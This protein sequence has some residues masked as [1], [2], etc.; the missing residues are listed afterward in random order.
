MKKTKILLV[1]LLLTALVGALALVSKNQNTQKGA[2]FA[3]TTLSILP[4]EKITKAVGE[5]L[6]TTVWFYTENSSTKV[7]G[8]QAKVCYGNELSL[9]ETS[10]AVGNTDAGFDESP[11]ISVIKGSSQSCAIVAATSKKSADNLTTTAKAITLNFSAVSAGSG[12][13]V[14]DKEGSM[15]TG[16]NTAS[17]TDKTLAIT[18]VAGTSY[19]ITGDEVVTGDEPILNYKIAYANVK[20]SSSG[21]VVD[22]PMQV[23]VLGGGVSKAYTNIIPSNMSTVGETLVAKGTM[24]LTG[25]D[26]FSDLAVFLKGPKHLQMKYAIQNQSVAYDKAGG[27]L[28]LTSDSSTSTVYDFTAYPMIPGDVSG[29]TD[30]VQDGWIDGIDFAY[31]KARALTHDTVEEGEYLLSDLDGNCQVN[32]NDINVLKISLQT[33]QGQLY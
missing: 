25:F 30:G 26:D 33:K 29:A 5:V 31:V 9:D 19:E 27:E 22:W 24:V 10:G 17:T 14:I 1:L 13:I 4:S 3:N 7:D 16:E 15:V 21:C 18:S 6:T 12:I 28:D 20:A 2:T 32:S 8:V 11:I 23:I